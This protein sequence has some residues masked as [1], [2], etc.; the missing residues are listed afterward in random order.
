MK[1]RKEN[2]GRPR[3]KPFPFAGRDTGMAAGWVPGAIP[4]LAVTGVDKVA[5][6]SLHRI[7]ERQADS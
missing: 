4:V 1:D 2:L 3:G 5:T 6:I 7:R